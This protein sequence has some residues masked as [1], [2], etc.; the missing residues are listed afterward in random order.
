MAKPDI[1]SETPMTLAETKKVLEDI[2]ER[3]KE[4]SFRSG[5]TYDYLSNVHAD[6]KSKE[7]I[8]KI[9]E[10]NIPRL[11]PEQIVKLVDLKPETL[12]EIKVILQGATITAENFK[13][14]EAVIVKDAE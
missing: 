3:D 11:K 5:K 14:L 13:K 7:K 12:E 1:I 6:E 4:F 10:L 2:K 9:E 8:K